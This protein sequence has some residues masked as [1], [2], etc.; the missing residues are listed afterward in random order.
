M[1]GNSRHN[2]TLLIIKIVSEITITKIPYHPKHNI[3]VKY[4][5]CH[6]KQNSWIGNQAITIIIMLTTKCPMGVVPVGI[7]D[8]SS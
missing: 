6:D 5:A 3:T 1:Y 8:T 2:S 7:S 4:N